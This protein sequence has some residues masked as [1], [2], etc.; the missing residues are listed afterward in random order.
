M[1]S[2][3]NWL[4]LNGMVLLNV[5]I[6][7]IELVCDKV[8]VAVKAIKDSN[9]P[10]LLLFRNR[11]ES[12]WLVKENALPVLKDDHLCYS[13]KDKRFYEV[14]GDHE[15][16]DVLKMDDIIMAELVDVSG[17]GIC[18]MS[19]FLHSVKWTSASASAPSVYEFVLVNTFL[20]KMCLSEEYLSNCILN[21]TTLQI[22]LVSIQLSNPLAK[23]DFLSWSV[24]VGPEDEEDA[25]ADAEAAAEEQPVPDAAEEQPVPD[26]A[27]EQ[28]LP[29]ASPELNVNAL[30]DSLFIN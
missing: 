17:L 21:V 25:V 29:D 23:D 30:G 27:E 28:P 22:P 10:D 5:I 15:L 4:M 20:S 6:G 13:V 16:S 12:P 8:G 14:I 7:F 9:V 2:L 18:D 24:F 3:Y 19:E 1:D 26:A 11:N